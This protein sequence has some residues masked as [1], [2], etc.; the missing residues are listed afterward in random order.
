MRSLVVACLLVA[1]GCLNV[2]KAHTLPSP[3]A[4]ADTWAADPEQ[5]FHVPISTAEAVHCASASQVE[6]VLRQFTTAFN[7]GSG[8]AI[9][10]MLSSELWAVS[11]NVAGKAEA[12]YGRGDA[13]RYL[14]DRYDSGDR[15]RFVGVKVNDLVGWDGAAQFGPIDFTLA[16]AGS[17]ID[18]SGKGALYCGGAAS[19]IKVLGLGDGKGSGT[20]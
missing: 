10:R 11:L 9:E 14:V 17:P 5:I 20:Q 2:G 3:S 16:R 19:G 1:T 6:E 4:T 13:A 12:A 18:I 7:S 15:L 8:D